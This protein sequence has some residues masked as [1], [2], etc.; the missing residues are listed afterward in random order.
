MFIYVRL[1]YS[2]LIL[3]IIRFL[4]LKVALKSSLGQISE[5]LKFTE[6]LRRA[7]GCFLG[8]HMLLGSVG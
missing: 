4:N 2:I 1:E 3:S 6:E 8:S 5:K 7:I